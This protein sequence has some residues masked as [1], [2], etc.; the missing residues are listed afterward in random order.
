[1][2][3]DR[4]IH[5]PRRF[6]S[7]EWGGTET[8]IGSLALQQKKAGWCPEIHTSL[9][10]STERAGHWEGVPI[11]RY[12]YCYPFFG[13]SDAEKAQMD[14]KGGNLLSLP[15]FFSLAR[16][17]GVRLFHAHA[18]K[19]L[20]GAVF[21]AARCSGRPF[22]VTLHGGVF[23]VPEAE[24]S[25]MLEAQQGKMEWGKAF[26]ALFRSRRILQ[27]ADAVICVGRSEYDRARASLGHDRIY[28]VGNGVEPEHFSSGDGEAF[29]HRHAIPAKATVLGCYSRLDPQKNQLLLLEAFD[30]LAARHPDLH[31]VLAGPE[32]LPAYVQ[33]IDA[34]VQASPHRNRIRRL[35]PLSFGGGELAGAY[36]ACDVFVLPSRH[37]PFGIVVLEAWSAGRPVV[38]SA[39]GGLQHL[40]SDGVDGLFFPSG[41][42]EACRARI[43][44]LL[45]DAALRERLGAAGRGKA[46]ESYSWSRIAQATE[47]IYQRAGE[48]QARR[49][50]S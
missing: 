37:E 33:K 24:L 23:D 16:Q 10:L 32:T 36:H 14:K 4:I 1:M 15:L 26:G 9:A 19:R 35:G 29:R 27:E 34:R 5:V 49:R 11:R 40:V 38:V 46:T 50:S 28:H 21:S 22:V 17:R 48:Q 42:V 13:L 20:G 41:D 12:S 31:L 43:E 47:E 25:E 7:H 2:K 44:T 45:T 8:V 30:V 18:L 3:S 6:V 39:V